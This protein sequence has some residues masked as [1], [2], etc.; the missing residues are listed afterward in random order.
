MKFLDTVA[1]LLDKMTEKFG[2]L[3]AV[4]GM[5]AFSLWVVAECCALIK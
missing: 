2:M 1:N 4:A 5:V 3:V